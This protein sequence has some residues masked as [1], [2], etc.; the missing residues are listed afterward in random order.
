MLGPHSHC[1]VLCC[2]VLDFRKTEATFGLCEQDR[3][4]PEL[5]LELEE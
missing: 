4:N 3:E 1:A 5:E 2:A